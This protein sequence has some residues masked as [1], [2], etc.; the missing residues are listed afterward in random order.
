MISIYRVEE[1]QGA[2]S[3]VVGRIEEGCLA[4]LGGGALTSCMRMLEGSHNLLL[5]PFCDFSD[6]VSIQ[7][8]RS[9]R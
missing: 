9:N 1:M 6:S 7:N 8:D 5:A 4:G 2:A 3:G